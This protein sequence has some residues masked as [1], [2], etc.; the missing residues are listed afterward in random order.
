M[1]E[2]V[3]IEDARPA[4]EAEWRRLWAGYNAF[5]EASVAPQVTD[6]TWQ[7]MLDPASPLLGRV[8]RR[9]GGLAGFSISVLHEGTWVVAPVCYLEDL[10]VDPA[11]RGLGIGRR[12][13]ADLVSLGKARGWS[14]LYWHTR[15]DNPARALYDRFVEADDFVRYRMEL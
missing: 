14:R 12:L 1:S 13:I 15:R 9:G 2:A 11:C 7:R 10:F 3:L 4:D 5:Y 8:A 6:R